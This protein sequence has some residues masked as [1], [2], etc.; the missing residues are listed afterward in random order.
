LKALLVKTLL[1]KALL[2]QETR[3]RAGRRCHSASLPLAMTSP[4]FGS[5]PDV[6]RAGCSGLEILQIRCQPHRGDTG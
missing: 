4:I 1:V 2:A 3:W 6:T 5:A